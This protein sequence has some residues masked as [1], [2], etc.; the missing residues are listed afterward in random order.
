MPG[1]HVS[2]LDAQF[3]VGKP[4]SQVAIGNFAARRGGSDFVRG[5]PDGRLDGVLF[6]LHRH[7]DGIDMW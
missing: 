5:R 1:R 6:E 3:Y 4:Y 2:Q 7:R